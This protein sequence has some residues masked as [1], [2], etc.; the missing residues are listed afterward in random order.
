MGRLSVAGSGRSGRLPRQRCFGG[1]PGVSRRQRMP[2]VACTMLT[3]VAWALAGCGPAV[4]ASAVG[5]AGTAA[6]APALGSAATTAAGPAVG[7][8]TIV[9]T[10]SLASARTT[11]AAQT[12]LRLAGSG[13]ALAMY[14]TGR[15]MS[16]GRVTLYLTSPAGAR[17]AVHIWKYG[18]Q[19]Q[20]AAWSPDRSKA[21]FEAVSPTGG[22]TVVHQMTL[23][24]GATTSFLLPAF[25]RVIG[26]AQPDGASVF[27]AEDSGIYRYS[28][29]GAELA[30]LSAVS[31][32]SND[33]G[34]G[35]A[36]MFRGGREIVVP[37]R[38]GLSLVSSSGV[39]LRMLRVPHTRGPCLPVRWNSPGVVVATCT[40]PV[41]SSG[42]QVFYVPVSG[43]A[44]V[45]VSAVR[46]FTS[47]DYGDI[48][49]WR[50][51]GSTYL[52]AEQSCGAGFLA[53][54][55]AGGA[56]T[57]VGI[58]GNPESTVVDGVY[59]NRMLLTETGCE[60]RNALALLDLATHTAQTILPY[61]TGAG[62]FDVVP[63]DG[64]GSQ[65]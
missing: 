11:A 20:L 7:S 50:I 56:I 44:P 21:I 63:Y 31:G 30:A 35:G 51:D 39:L 4:G 46:D 23:A 5:S 54:E 60:N 29:T 43:A 15:D 48:D 38:Q 24:S 41:T 19:W 16:H 27:V 8:G 47:G 58:P 12:P 61:G 55:G 36:V 53:S 17:Y 28:L 3:P 2:W 62:A 14:A 34:S 32:Q 45:A 59:G 40:P 10:P 18:T 33:L 57:P 22:L 52:Q 1:R 6:A 64:N 49:A 26:Y 42:P 65:P 9:A 25:S 37:A 13:W